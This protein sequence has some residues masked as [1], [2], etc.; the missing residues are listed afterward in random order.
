[1]LIRRMKNSIVL[2]VMTCLFVMASTV[3]AG[4]QIIQGDFNAVSG[5]GGGP[6]LS[7]QGFNELTNWDDA[8]LGENAF[9]GTVGN[10]R[11]NPASA[12]GSA[13]G[14]VGGSGAG[15]VD[16]AGVTFDILDEPFS[17]VTNTGG[18]IF[19][20][21]DG[22][23]PDT[24]GFTP[25]WDD[26]ITGEGAFGGTF[27]GA[28]LIGSMLAEGLPTGGLAGGGGRIVVD[29]VDTT[30]GNFDE[31]FSSA[32]GVG[33][34]PF[35]PGNSSDWDTGLVNQNAFFGTF[36]NAVI[37]VGASV[38]GC[39]TCGVGGTG[40]AQLTIS[41]VPPNTGGWFAGMCFSNVPANLSVGLDQITL[42]ANIQGT[43]NTASGET[44]EPTSFLRIEDADLTALSFTVTADG[45]FQSVGGLLGSAVL[46][47]INVGDGIF[48]VN[49]AT[50]TLTVGFVGTAT[51]W[52]P[53]GTLTLDNLFLSGIQFGDADTYTVALSFE[54]EI[55]SWGTAGTLTIDN[56]SFAQSVVLTPGDTNCDGFV[57]GLDVQSFVLAILDPAGYAVQFPMCNIL[58][59]DTNGDT[60][61]DTGD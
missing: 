26:G 21:G 45:A 57:N 10:A 52:G 43:A 46:E 31:N 4:A 29:T 54:N 40:G 20:L 22:I 23:T 27:G 13:T 2:S 5:T 61:V 41:D 9:A 50:Y 55:A 35:P 33:G 7:G 28:V 51:N 58:N 25:N 19:L 15:V 11:V 14:G 37:N 6:I 49:Q 30:F 38:Q 12:S 34:G 18:G 48:D 8:L 47:Q 17:T 59:A 42:S 32:T 44:W 3:P 1:M 56:L 16:I 24:S 60:N 36:G 53:G 39:T